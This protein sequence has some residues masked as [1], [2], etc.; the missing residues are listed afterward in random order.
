[1]LLW[2]K[3]MVDRIVDCVGSFSVAC[4]FRIVCE[5]FKWAS[6]GVYAPDGDN[7]RKLLWDE[8]VGLMSWWEFP[9]CI[10]GD[11]NIIRYLCER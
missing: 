1:V 9:W 2:D 4:S 7:D 3:R 8:L 11:F 6:E 5:I 10:R